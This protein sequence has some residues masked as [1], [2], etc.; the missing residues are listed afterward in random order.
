[1]ADAELLPG[2]ARA[3]ALAAVIEGA[4]GVPAL[5]AHARA[6]RELAGQMFADGLGPESVTRVLSLLNDRLTCRLI[7]IV[8][9]RCRLP[10]ADWCWIG[11]GSEGRVEQTLTTDQD[12]GLI[13]A[14]SDEREARELRAHFLPFAQAMNHALAECGFPLCDGEVMAGNPKWCLSLEEW[15]RQFAFWIRTPDPQA[16]LNATIFFDFRPLAGGFSL[17]AG[18][19]ASL[20]TLARGNDIFLRM[21]TENALRAIPPLG[22]IKDFTVEAGRLDLKK[23]GSRLFVDAARILSLADGVPSPLTLDRLRGAAVAGALRPEEAESSCRAFLTIQALRLEVQRAAGNDNLVDPGRLG[24]FERTVLLA[25]L[26]QA[27][28]LQRILKTRF[29]IES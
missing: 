21:M 1:M 23:S 5:A 12:N 28:T 7:A 13:F 6:A 14:A 20:T 18:L 19:R 3:S 2:T 9:R 4:E 8:S 29:Q 22:L 16:L 26:R 25:A 15:Q 27:R 17:A 24:E 10:P 11:L